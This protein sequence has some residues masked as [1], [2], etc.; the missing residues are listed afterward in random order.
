MLAHIY[1]VAVFFLQ[2]LQVTHS[3]RDP[4]RPGVYFPHL[5]F[6]RARNGDPRWPEALPLSA[7]MHSAYFPAHFWY[8]RFRERIPAVQRMRA[9]LFVVCFSPAAFRS[10]HCACQPR[11]PLEQNAPCI[12]LRIDVR[13][14]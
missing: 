14:L 4:F 9:F 5:S 11:I 8:G 6:L 2:A 10:T 13:A 7:G 3:G 1:N 12:F